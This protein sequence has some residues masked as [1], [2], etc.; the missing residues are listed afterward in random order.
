MEMSGKNIISLEDFKEENEGNLVKLS[1]TPILLKQE[2]GELSGYVELFSSKDYV[3][4]RTGGVH[5]QEQIR[6]IQ[7]GYE[8]SKYMIFKGQKEKEYLRVHEK[9]CRDLKSEH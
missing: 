1:G 9:P 4:F 7:E 3:P 5:Q 2:N 8:N 6:I